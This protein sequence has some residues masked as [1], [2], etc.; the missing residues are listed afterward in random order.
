MKPLT[1][2]IITLLLTFTVV[3]VNGEEKVVKFSVPIEYQGLWA[4]IEKV[5][6]GHWKEQVRTSAPLGQSFFTIKE[7]TIILPTEGMPDIVLKIALEL[8]L[9]FNILTAY[10]RNLFFEFN[11]FDK[12]YIL[13]YA[14]PD[15]G[16]ETNSLTIAGT[17]QK[18]PD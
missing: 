4:C 3:P 7:D 18:A 14:N 11:T 5:K 12:N 15:A 1:Q 2:L 9:T 13:F 10:T 8:G 6:T 17:C 16:V